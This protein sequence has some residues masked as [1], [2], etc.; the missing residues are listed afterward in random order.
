MSEQA[1]DEKR[2]L[3]DVASHKMTIEQDDGE[4][5]RRLLFK[6]E[7]GSSYW[8][9]L[10]TWPGALCITGDMGTYV[11][12]RTHDM[13]D[14]FIMDK[15]DF[16][17]RPENQLNINRG[18]WAE[19]CESASKSNDKSICAFSI[20][21]FM[22]SVRDYL[23]SA[24]NYELEEVEAILDSPGYNEYDANNENARILAQVRDEIFGCS[25]EWEAIDAVRSFRY[26]QGNKVEFEFSD[27]FGDYDVTEYTHHYVW[28]L[29]AIVWGITQ[30]NASKQV[31]AE[32]MAA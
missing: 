12:S 22:Q 2:F 6:K 30:H 28:C 11:F 7:N 18:Y 21:V 27:F 19:K 3:N 17:S 13:F 8:F 24:F 14:F 25:D 5:S 32:E 31:K 1:L 16:N 4:V 26:Y 9:R 23:D 29:Y 15:N 10:V 20:D